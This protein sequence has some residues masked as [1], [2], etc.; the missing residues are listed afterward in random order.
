MY[1]DLL[2][3]VDG[4]ESGRRRVQFAAGLAGSTGARLSGIHVTP[5]PEVPPL[6]KPTRVEE[7]A[8]HLSSQLALQAAEAAAV[9]RAEVSGRQADTC[10]FEATGDVVE[11]IRDRARYADLVIVGQ[12]EWQGSPETHP[13]PIAHSVVVRCGRP[14]LVVPAAVQLGSLANVAI[15]WDGSREAVRAVHDALPLLRLARSVRVVTNSPESTKSGDDDAESL[16]AHLCRHGVAVEADVH[17]I[18]SA[19]AHHA[20]RKQIEQGPYDLLVMGG[21]SHPMWMEF[22][23]GG[24][25]ES[26]LLS[27]KIPVLVSH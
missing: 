16:L 1:R 13:L 4:S 19:Q 3:H 22:V 2:V 7:V 20:L 9:F 25:T 10:W 26:I 14:V 5:P 11:G 8:A 17:R 23:F 18:G 6:Y 12:Y 27:L 21:Y 24:V 15:A